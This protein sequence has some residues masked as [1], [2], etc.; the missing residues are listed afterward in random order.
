MVLAPAPSH[1]GV[2]PQ[3]ETRNLQHEC[4]WKI[5]SRCKRDP[6]PIGGHILDGTCL[7][8]RG[9]FEHSLGTVRRRLPAMPA[10]IGV[11]SHYSL[12]LLMCRLLDA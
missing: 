11:S 1:M 7:S 12:S 2:N 10:T 4:G 8:V 5:N 9:A 6:R 3:T